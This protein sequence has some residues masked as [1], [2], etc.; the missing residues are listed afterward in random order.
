MYDYNGKLARFSSAS[1]AL[2]ATFSSNSLEAM[3]STRKPP[4]LTNAAERGAPPVPKDADLIPW[5]LSI[6]Y[7]L[8]MDK[9][10]STK[11]KYLQTLNFSGD[12]GLTKNWRIGATSGY[13]FVSKQI[14][15]TSVNIYRDLKCW[16]ARIDWIP[17]GFRKSY[18]LTINI[19][20]SMLNDLKLT[21]AKPPMSTD[22]F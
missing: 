11:I 1:F 9:S 20:S 12:V 14:S 7:V 6:Y 15:Y 13:D 19:K 2:N 8:T 3:R 4:N 18:S 17:F 22:N 16:E 21:K 5:N 10:R